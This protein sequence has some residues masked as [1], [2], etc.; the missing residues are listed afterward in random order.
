MVECTS[1]Q[2]SP[3][4]QDQKNTSSSTGYHQLSPSQK[5][6]KRK[7]KE[8][9]NRKRPTTV[10]YF[11]ASVEVP[12]AAATITAGAVVVDEVLTSFS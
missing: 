8:G 3:T 6:E 9:K 10:D 2:A 11:G 1:S 7:G 4:D 12:G 5:K